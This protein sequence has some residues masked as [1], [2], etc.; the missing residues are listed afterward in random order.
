MAGDIRFKIVPV[1]VRVPSAAPKVKVIISIDFKNEIE[2]N[3]IIH[4]IHRNKVSM[5]E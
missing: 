3:K 1:W 4:V 2:I 5:H